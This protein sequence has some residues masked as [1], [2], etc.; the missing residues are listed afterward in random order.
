MGDT[1]WGKRLVN[2][3]GNAAENDW[4]LTEERFYFLHKKRPC[5]P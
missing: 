4:V 5:N 3:Y 2:G 1:T